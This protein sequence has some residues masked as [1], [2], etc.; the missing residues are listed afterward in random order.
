[1]TTTVRQLLTKKGNLV[2][3]ISPYA[4]VLEAITKLAELK[5]GALLV[6][7]G[8]NLL[9]IISERDYARNI[10][11]K[12]RS[13]KTT[14]VQEIMTKKVLYVS[15]LNDI[16][17]C[18]AIMVE[19]RIRHLPVIENENIT[20]VISISDVIKIIISEKEFIIEQLEQYITG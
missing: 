10:I 16:N 12:D 6:M 8:E 17:E 4:T 7:D 14:S 13:S 1:M 2:H 5:I 18:M 19:N 3:S 20:G 11:L 9:G 15:P